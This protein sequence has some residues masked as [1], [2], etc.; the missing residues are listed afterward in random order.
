MKWLAQNVHKGVAEV[1]IETMDKVLIVDIDPKRADLIRSLLGEHQ[2]NAKRCRD[3]EE[4]TTFIKADFSPVII[5][6]HCALLNYSFTE[7]ATLSHHSDVRLLFYCTDADHKSAE[8]IA[9]LP[10]EL[11]EVIL[12]IS[13]SRKIPGEN[14]LRI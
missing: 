8:T 3:F 6:V 7:L 11:G 10:E 2:I 12:R 14:I 5:F 9:K 1:F 4:I 13:E